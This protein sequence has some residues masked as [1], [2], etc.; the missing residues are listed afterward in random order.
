MDHVQKVI[1]FQ[2]KGMEEIMPFDVHRNPF[3]MFPKLV[4]MMGLRDET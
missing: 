4:G 1:V 2:A 3:G